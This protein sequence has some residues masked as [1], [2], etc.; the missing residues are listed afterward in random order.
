MENCFF[1][2]LYKLMKIQLSI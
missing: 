2:K 1:N